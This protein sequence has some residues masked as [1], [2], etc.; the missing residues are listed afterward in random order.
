MSFQMDVKKPIP[1]EAETRT[2]IMTAAK[3]IGCFE[4]AKKIIDWHDAA[5][6]THQFD[7]RATE[8]IAINCIVSLAKLDERLVLWL[9][10]ENGEIM[11][12]NKPI[13]KLEV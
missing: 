8:A 9:V 10:N 2:K 7:P 3:V 5:F 1:T 4:E 13:L 12:A 11:V 6:R